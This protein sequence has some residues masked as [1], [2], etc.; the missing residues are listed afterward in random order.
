M[1]IL[2]RYNFIVL[3][4]ALSLS[5]CLVDDS[6]ETDSYGD[7]PNLVSFTSESIS[8]SA[9]TNGEEFARSIPITIIGPTFDEIS[10]PVTVEVEIDPSSTAESGVHYQLESTSFTIN[11]GDELPY[12]LPITIL[13]DGL[14]APLDETPVLNVNIASITTESNVV[15]NAKNDELQVNLA[16]A[17]PFDISNYEGTYIATT[18]EFG[19]YNGDAVE[20]EIVQGPGENQITL[21]QVANQDYDVV[22]DVDPSNGDLNIAK[23]VALNS[24]AIG[25]S[26]G[27]LS[28]EGSGSS[29]ASSGVCIGVLD[30]TAGYTV[31][32]GSFGS[33]RTVFEK[34]D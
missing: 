21:Q 2:N 29:S 12:N 17:C 23:Q 11:P 25:Y 5:S 4:V 24:N 31:A 34:V 7:G 6:A 27:E 28:W 20:F 22:I 32:A 16:Y 19:I 26:Y 3:L 9:E 14:E 18:D 30:F 13:T 1:K 33:F 8:L 10:E 15:I